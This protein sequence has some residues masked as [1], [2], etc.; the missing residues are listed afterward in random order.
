MF[1]A[2]TFKMSSPG[3]SRS[4]ERVFNIGVAGRGVSLAKQPGKRCRE[5]G[6]RYRLRAVDTVLG[7]Q[8]LSPS[9]KARPCR[10][11]LDEGGTATTSAAPFPAL[12]VASESRITVLL[13]AF[14]I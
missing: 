4:A 6:M 3:S 2:G 7:Q 12:G 11:V 1:P 8:P 5:A 14:R 10:A 13:D 9:M